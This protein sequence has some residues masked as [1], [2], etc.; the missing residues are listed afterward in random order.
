VVQELLERYGDN[1]IPVF[2]HL[3]GEAGRSWSNNRADFYNLRYTPYLWFNGADDAGYNSDTW[4]D[5]LRTHLEQETDVTIDIF[6]SIKGPILTTLAK[7]CIEED[8]VS[9]DLR[10]VFSQILDNFPQT[11]NYYRNALRGGT[12]ENVFVNAGSCV[13]VS[14]LMVISQTD[15]ESPEN[16]GVIVWAQ[17]PVAIAPAEVY[18]VAIGG[19]RLSIPPESRSIRKVRKPVSSRGE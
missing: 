3:G 11:A 16:F 13:D 7:V 8:G 10:M 1:F 14:T 9:R 19:R 6:T 18:Q 17:E 2:Y 15:V 4:E 5:R 12:T